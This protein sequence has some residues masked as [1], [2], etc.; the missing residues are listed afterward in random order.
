[1]HKIIFDCTDVIFFEN[2]RKSWV[3]EKKSTCESDAHSAVW[4]HSQLGELGTGFGQ[5]KRHPLNPNRRNDGTTAVENFLRMYLIGTLS[6]FFCLSQIFL[7]TKWQ[8]CVGV[9]LIFE[10]EVTL[11]VKQ[12]TKTNFWCHIHLNA[13]IQVSFVEQNLSFH[14]K[15]V[16]RIYKKTFEASSETL[17]HTV[18][19]DKFCTR[20]NNKQ[21]LF[22]EKL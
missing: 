11:L 5:K 19:T 2:S 20:N 7:F 18:I 10:R 1:M 21:Q 8:R 6:N 16:Q 9:I 17:Q 12:A 15:F 13:V 4:W 3:S 14:R 22:T